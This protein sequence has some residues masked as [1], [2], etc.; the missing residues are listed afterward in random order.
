MV[1]NSLVRL[2]L[3]YHVS[4]YNQVGKLL[5]FRNFK[6]PLNDL[7]ILEVK[8]PLNHEEQIPKILYP[9]RLRLTRCSKYVL[10]CE[11]LGLS[12]GTRISFLE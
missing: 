8:S 12:T 6:I 2:T 1:I 5:P 4:C 11:K 7:V 3:D 10:C 9:L